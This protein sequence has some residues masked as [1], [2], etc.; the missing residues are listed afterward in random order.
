MSTGT[1]LAHSDAPAAGGEG[2]ARRN[3]W[4][5][6]ASEPVKRNL[7]LIGVLI[8]LVV[9]G[10][11]TR[12]DLYA[13]AGWFGDNVFVIL[14]QSAAIGVITVGM[15][16]VIIGGGIDLS[17][18]AIV[19]LAGLGATTV[20]TQ[21]FGALGMVF[22]ARAVGVVVGLVNGLLISYGRLVP[23][24][25]TLAML[26]AARGLAAQISKKQTQISNNVDINAIA[27][28]RILGVPLL[29]IILAVVVA[30]GWIL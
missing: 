10:I 30:L 18:G 20:A 1:E 11:I 8:A 24:I 9:I 26:V 3:W 17:V 19:A 22:T 25:A 13:L 4:R 12:P 29:V 5:D 21:S 28:M 23:F 27:T 14:Q 16:F 15:T 7:G 2:P 6:E